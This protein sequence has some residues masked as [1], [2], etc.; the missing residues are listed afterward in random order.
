MEYSFTFIFTLEVLLKLVG[1][2]S[3]FWVDGWNVFDFIVVSASLAE[4][5]LG[6]IVASD[7]YACGLSAIRLFRVFRVL[8][9][10]GRLSKP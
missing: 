9:V 2:G 3:V 7:K 1:L 5:V 8:R 6:L 10:A 4:V